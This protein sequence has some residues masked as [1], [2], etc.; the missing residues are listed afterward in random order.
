MQLPH[1]IGIF[2]VLALLVHFAI[3]YPY[4]PEIMATHF[5]AGG[6]PNG[7]MSKEGF[8]LFEVV[9]ISF[10]AFVKFGLP[11][12]IK[13]VPKSLINIPNRDYW[14]SAKQRGSTL[15]TL[16]REMGWVFIGVLIFLITI[17]Q[18]VYQANLDDNKVLSNW[19]LVIFFGFLRFIAIWIVRFFIIFKLPKD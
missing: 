12:L 4:L 10:V 11:R 6:E 18:L 9:L 16:N 13:T 19:I 2:L 5:G 17:N 8:I 7:W 14:L 15:E 1:K 3:Y